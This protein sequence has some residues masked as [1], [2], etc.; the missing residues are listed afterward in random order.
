MKIL[1]TQITRQQG[2]SFDTILVT[3]EAKNGEITGTFQIFEQVKAGASLP[4]NLQQTI[5]SRAQAL[6][7]E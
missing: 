5:E 7:A 1:I 2:E 4:D 6:L 3:G